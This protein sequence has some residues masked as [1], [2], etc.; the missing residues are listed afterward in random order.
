MIWIN[1]L[2]PSLVLV[3]FYQNT[4]CHIPEYGNLEKELSFF[5]NKLCSFLA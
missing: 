1:I 2:P 4:Q 5:A 3:N